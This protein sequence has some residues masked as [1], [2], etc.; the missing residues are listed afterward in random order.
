MDGIE[1][2]PLYHI[3]DNTTSIKD[4]IDHNIVYYS[5]KVPTTKCNEIYQ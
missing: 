5:I 2:N 1:Y 3:L 4:N